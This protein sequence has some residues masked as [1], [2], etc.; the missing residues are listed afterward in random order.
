M[1]IGPLP[2]WADKRLIVRLNSSDELYVIGGNAHTYRG[3]VEL[4]NL[5]E[6][7]GIAVFPREIVAITDYARGWLEGFLSGN[8][9]AL[10]DSAAVADLRGSRELEYFHTHQR[11]LRSSNRGLYWVR[12]RSENNSATTMNDIY[13]SLSDVFVAFQHS[14]VLGIAEW[15]PIA[16]FYDE[17]QPIDLTGPA[18]I[19]D[20]FAW[21]NPG[22]A[23]SD[24]ATA[25]RT[26]RVINCDQSRL[27][28]GAV[29]VVISIQTLRGI[30]YAV[31][32]TVNLEEPAFE[33]GTSSGQIES[34]LATIFEI[35]V[36]TVDP[37]TA[38][39]ST[40]T[41]VDATAVYP[42]DPRSNRDLNTPVTP[43]W[44]TYVA[45]RLHFP[46]ADIS[47]TIM[48]SA[49]WYTG[50]LITATPRLNDFTLEAAERVATALGYRP[51]EGDADYVSEAAESALNSTPSAH[52]LP[53]SSN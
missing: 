4:Y 19:R 50:V 26:L 49:P 22:Y 8:E 24:N 51:D 9:P 44:L 53:E 31:E 40:W 30:V 3:R 14:D 20:A 29:E 11:E 39:A 10:P 13:R 25:A 38:T 35:L 28:S 47:G 46:A 23:M 32:M 36:T 43:G 34:I 16:R 7:Y 27:P 15:S 21:V 17:G 37:D 6:G 52:S 5:A 1:T 18:E 48:R 2:E 42:P 33:N 12:A 45:D 41:A